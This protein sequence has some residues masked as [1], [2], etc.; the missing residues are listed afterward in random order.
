M[1]M[2]TFNPHERQQMKSIFIALSEKKAP[3]GCLLW[4]WQ[5][6]LW[7]WNSLLL[8]SLPAP[9][10]PLFLK[11]SISSSLREKK[12]SFM[13]HLKPDSHRKRSYHIKNHSK[14]PNCLPPACLNYS[15]MSL[16]FSLFLPFVLQPC[17]ESS[18]LFLIKSQ[19]CCYIYWMT[20]GKF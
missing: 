20:P 2:F 12:N 6:R 15:K 19:Y 1:G 4:I 14:I 18:S 5:H 10:P 8:S 16:D 17:W 13:H 3:V 9:S 11:C 7:C